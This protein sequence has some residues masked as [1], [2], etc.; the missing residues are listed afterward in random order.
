MKT[1]I[2][3]TTSGCHLCEEAQALLLPVLAYFEKEAGHSIA[4]REQEISESE[5]MVEAYGIRIPV[6]QM[7]GSTSELG[8]PFDQAQAYGFIVEALGS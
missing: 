8:W 1:L 6:I 4:L 7:E 3:Y 2:L 5:A